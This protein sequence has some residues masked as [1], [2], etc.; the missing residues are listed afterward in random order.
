MLSGQLLRGQE[1]L[2][3]Q[4][5]TSILPPTILLQ[6]G[7]EKVWWLKMALCKSSSLICAVPLSRHVQVS[8]FEEAH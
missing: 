2:S 7:N 1:C 8:K 4:L 6:K 5:H 3:N